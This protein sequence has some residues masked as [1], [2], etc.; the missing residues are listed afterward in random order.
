MINIHVTRKF[1]PLYLICETHIETYLT[2]S[3]DENIKCYCRLLPTLKLT[4]LW[5]QQVGWI[6]T[7]AKE[8]MEEIYHLLYWPCFYRL[9]H[10]AAKQRRIQLLQ[11]L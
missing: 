9:L 8:S 5:L 1:R 11:S 2:I 7:K 3:K 6:H 10:V 4:L